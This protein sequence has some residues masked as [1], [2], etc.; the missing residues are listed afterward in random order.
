MRK[1]SVDNRTQ[2]WYLQE[3]I[4]S[5]GRTTLPHQL[6]LAVTT[7]PKIY[8]KNEGDSAK[9]I[10]L[11]DDEKADMRRRKNKCNYDDPC[12][13]S[14]RKIFAASI[15]YKDHDLLEAIGK[16]NIR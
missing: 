13:D 7:G 1:F 4:F 6:S 5:S 12:N 2:I 11:E 3:I 14:E 10:T 16:K 8:D 9:H 15:T